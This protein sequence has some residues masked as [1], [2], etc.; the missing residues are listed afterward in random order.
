MADTNAHSIEIGCV[1]LRIYICESNGMNMHIYLVCFISLSLSLSL[2][3]SRFM[4]VL[5]TSRLQQVSLCN[6][7]KVYLLMLTSVYIFI[8]GIHIHIHLYICIPLYLFIHLF[9]YI[10]PPSGFFRRKPGDS[11]GVSPSPSLLREV[12]RRSHG[13]SNSEGGPR[14]HPTGTGEPILHTYIYIY[15]EICIYTHVYVYMYNDMYS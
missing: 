5:G 13:L 15:I 9:S 2:S 12:L 11:Q 10:P 7:S 6:R 14:P 3:V 4:C 8:S 1:T